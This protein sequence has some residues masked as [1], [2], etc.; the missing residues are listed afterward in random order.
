MSAAEDD[1]A[2]EDTGYK[3][4]AM[5]S[6]DDMTK[7]DADDEALNK[8]KAQ[9]LGDSAGASAG[10]PKVQVLKMEL[11][12]EGKV[13]ALD[14]TGDL[15]SLEMQ[16]LQGVEYKIRITFKINN[17]VVAGLKYLAGIYRKGIRLAK[18]EHMLGS[19]GPK[20]EDQMATTQADDAPSGMLGRGTYT[21]KSKF[22]DDDKEV[23]LAWEWKLKVAKDW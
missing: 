10:G 7:L 8:W 9:L 23:H 3:A 12:S 20:A 21:I 19:Y 17:E 6:V 14:L 4:P 13:L 11:L 15:S 1:L 2:P 22:I 16:V 18:I 5:A